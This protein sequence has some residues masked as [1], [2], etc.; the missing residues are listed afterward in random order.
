M[1]QTQIAENSPHA[2][3]KKIHRH[4]KKICPRI[5]CHI[6]SPMAWMDYPKTPLGYIPTLITQNP[7][8]L[9]YMEVE[10]GP[11]ASTNSWYLNLCVV[12]QGST[13]RSHLLLPVSLSVQVQG[14][15]APST[16]RILN[17]KDS[18]VPNPDT[19]S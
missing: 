5:S 10:N 2:K 8:Q 16:A 13:N 7:L 9:I 17:A 6:W 12:L 3:I 4:P 14:A 19:P 18:L 11:L 1:P 15:T